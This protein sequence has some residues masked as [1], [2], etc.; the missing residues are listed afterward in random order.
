MESRAWRG[1]AEINMA[2]FR[3]VLTYGDCRRRQP[4]TAAGRTYVDG[5][6][7]QVADSESVRVLERRRRDQN[8]IF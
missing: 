2:S 8:K 3:H 1:H 7:E 4:C 5:G 6:G